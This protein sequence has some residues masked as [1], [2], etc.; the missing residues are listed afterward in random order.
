MSI[1]CCVRAFASALLGVVCVLFP[2]K[3]NAQNITA[4]GVA[5]SASLFSAL[6][7][8]C[9]KSFFINVEEA[10]RFEQAF[11][12]SGTKAF[13]KT[14]F[15]DLLALE[16]KRR[17]AEVKAAGAGKWCAE[18]RKY[19][20]QVSGGKIFDKQAASFGKT[21]DEMATLLSSLIVAGQ[22]CGLK[23]ND[24]PIGRVVAKYGLE[25]RA[26]LPGG[27][28]ELIVEEK[29]KKAE[30]FLVALGSEKGCEGVTGTVR[31][32]LPEVVE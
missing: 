28:Y 27:K 3:T 7:S 1:A 13:G 32:F 6:I 29:V 22:K 16:K 12:A 19:I 18:Q 5:R 8:Q 30:E 21:P 4:E 31:K 15:E 23:T 2:A 10:K 26:F 20:E 9:Q 17:L 25:L 11:V 14:K 24:V